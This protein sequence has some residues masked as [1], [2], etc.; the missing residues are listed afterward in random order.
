[1][2]S[3]IGVDR[4]GIVAAVAQC[5]A[6]RGLNI[7]DSQMGILR[8]HFAMTLVV[9]GE[10]VDAAAV[11][12]ELAA[13]GRDADL[14][15]IGLR[16]VADADPPAAQVTHTVTVYGADHPGI[17]AS[18]AGALAGA[19]VNVCDLRTWLTGDDVYVMVVDVA[20]PSD[21]DPATLLNAVASE[22]GVD[23]S[24]SDAGADVL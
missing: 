4:P 1:M 9:E 15:W 7:T 10:E 22:Q 3:A 6:R 17:V 16:A 24:V 14:E 20:A 18:V 8:G 13:V 5:L 12:R 21:C 23:V 2:V 19:G 11:E